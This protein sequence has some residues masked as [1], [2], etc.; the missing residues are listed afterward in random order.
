M[1]RGYDDP[2]LTYC[3]MVSSAGSLRR[4]PNPQALSF[5]VALD[6]GMNLAPVRVERADHDGARDHVGGALLAFGAS[7]HF[8]C[9]GKSDSSSG[10]W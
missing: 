8:S 2:S 10:Q 6:R 3:G 4:R 1:P 5:G 9:G 7:G